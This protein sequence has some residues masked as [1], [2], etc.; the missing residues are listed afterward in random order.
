MRMLYAGMYQ[1]DL[2]ESA[3]GERLAEVIE[4]CVN[5]G[6]VDLNTA[7]PHLLKVRRHY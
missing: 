3:L 1:H 2:P 5:C 4:E 6:G 7:S